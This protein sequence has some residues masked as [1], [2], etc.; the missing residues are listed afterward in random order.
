MSNFHLTAM[1]C[2]GRISTVPPNVSE[3]SASWKLSD[4]PRPHRANFPFARHTDSTPDSPNG[5]S[6]PSAMV[7][8]WANDFEYV[9]SA[10]TGK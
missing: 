10:S 8:G 9:A 6:E 5:V 7:R 3:W 4:E 2:L 1:E